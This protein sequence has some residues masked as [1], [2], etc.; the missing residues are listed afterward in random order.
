MKGGGS[1]E[2]RERQ[3]TEGGLRERGAA[4]GSAGSAVQ[5]KVVWWSGAGGRRRRG[6][7]R[8]GSEGELGGLGGLVLPRV[9]YFLGTLWVIKKGQVGSRRGGLAGRTEREDRRR[10]GK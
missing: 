4:G 8:Q 3:L 10:I 7:P 6:K 5:H 9:K 1:E 2:G